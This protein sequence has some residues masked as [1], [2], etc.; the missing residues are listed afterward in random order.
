[1]ELMDLAR[2]P[3][4]LPPVVKEEYHAVNPG[5]AETQARPGLKKE[6]DLDFLGSSDVLPRRE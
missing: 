4:G 5:K 1:M 2:Y 6:G 3:K